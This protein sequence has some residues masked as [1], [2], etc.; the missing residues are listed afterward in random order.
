MSDSV[1][2]DTTMT[3]VTS[4]TSTTSTPKG[5]TFAPSPPRSSPS[6][7]ILVNNDDSPD[8]SLSPDELALA[9][10]EVRSD[11]AQARMDLSAEKAIRKRKEKNL[12]KLAKQLNTRTTTIDDQQKQINGLIEAQAKLETRL[13]TARQELEQLTERY[14]KASRDHHAEITEQQTKHRDLCRQHDDRIAELTAAHGRQSEELRR[15][16][17]KS[18][19]DADRLR[20]QIASIEMQNNPDS[21][22]AVVKRTMRESMAS[23]RSSKTKGTGLSKS[24]VAA[25][26]AAFLVPTFA[27]FVFSG[28]A[29]CAPCIP[30]T[31]LVDA[32]FIGEAPWWAPESTKESMFGLLCGSDRIRARIEWSG[33][34]G[35]SM[36]IVTNA[37][38]PPSKQS[39]LVEKKAMKADVGAEKIRATRAN[40]KSEDIAAPW[41]MAD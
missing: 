28:D 15:D 14:E 22:D 4:N 21:A 23:S 37:N 8:A 5:V 36:L 35:V 33:G 27:Y 2:V 38:E 12:V 26:C 3:P 30:G 24:V 16:V 32:P 31:T 1:S 34:S 20:T 39:V 13:G 18:H 40:G 17:L 7:G 9:L 11:L 6:G 25:I 29:I 10:R 19:L 41:R